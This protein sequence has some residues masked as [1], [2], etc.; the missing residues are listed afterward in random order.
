MDTIRSMSVVELEVLLLVFLAF[1]QI[2]HSATKKAKKHSSNIA[3]R[4]LHTISSGFSAV[5]IVVTLLM[6]VFVI[7]R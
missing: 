2:A 1:F 6:M 7:V 5:M 4:E 3:A